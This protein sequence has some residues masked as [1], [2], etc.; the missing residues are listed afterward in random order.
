MT[1]AD[2]TAPGGVRT[3]TVRIPNLT[4]VAD[5]VDDFVRGRA[6]AGSVL[7]V[8]YRACE[9]GACPDP[10]NM[11]V[12]TNSD[13]RYRKNLPASVDVDGT[14]LFQVSYQSTHG[15]SFTRQARAPWM[16]IQARNHIEVGCQ[17]KG[18]TTVKL[19]KSDGTLRASKSLAVATECGF[20]SG[21]FRKNGHA[22]NIATSNRVSADF[23]SDA[24]LTWPAMSVGGSGTM[25]FGRCLK[26]APW[27]VSFQR[28]SGG[29]N[30][31]GTT[32]ANGDFSVD[33]GAPAFQSG[34]QLDLFC[35]STRGDFVRLART[36]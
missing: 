30:V 20:A 14:D 34:D 8:E 6:P 26:N 1:T 27:K 15:D 24:S 11:T 19:R 12:Q 5:R 7:A 13:G 18:T 28:S 29:D 2:P 17:A 32:D 35:E 36:L 31:R 33:V 16:V 10:V 4:A 22:V 9:V 25:L 3:R 23:A 21:S